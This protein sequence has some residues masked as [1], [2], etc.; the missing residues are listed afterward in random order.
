MDKNLQG[1]PRGSEIHADKSP[2]MTD[3]THHVV[4][5]P[6]FLKTL[7]RKLERP[8]LLLS[9]VWFLV[10]ITELVNG[11]SPLLQSL[12]TVLWALFVL[13]FGLRLA[14][15]PNRVGFSEAELALYLGDSR[16]RTSV[17]PF[18][19]IVSTGARADRNPWNASNL[20]VCLGRSR[21]AIAPADHGTEGNRLRAHIH[22][23]RD[24]SGC[25]RHASFRK[26][27]IGFTRHSQLSESSLVGRHADHQYWFRVPA[28]DTGR[29]G[30]LSW[31]FHLCCCH[32]RLSDCGLCR[33]SYW[34]GC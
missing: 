27:L 15:V 1:E 9:F 20:D 7:P 29:A 16:T 24:L 11:M 33:I 13:Y 4:T 5:K 30:T 17:N 31:H 34:A 18:P 2:Q 8:M 21:I 22:G 6:E 19:S 25:G 10:I 26:G 12:G 14:I 32:L 28:H 3:N 23:G